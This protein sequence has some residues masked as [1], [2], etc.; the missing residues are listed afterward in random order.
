MLSW[1]LYKL[2][3]INVKIGWE[4]FELALAIIL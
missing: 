3:S 2:F 1:I 4:L